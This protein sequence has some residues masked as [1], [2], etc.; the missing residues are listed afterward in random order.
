MQFI[1]LAAQQ[2]AIGQQIEKNIRNVISHGQYIMGPEVQ[3]LE[4]K[5]SAFCGVPFAVGCG[6]GTEALL[7]SLMALGVGPGDAVFCPTFTFIATAEVISLLGATPIFIDVEKTSFNLDPQCLSLAAKA[8]RNN[9]PN[10]YPLPHADAA[11]RPKAVIAVDLFG[12]PSD[13]GAIKNVAE[14]EGLAMV[15]DAAQSMGAVANGVRAGALAPLA[16]TSFFPAKPLGCYGDGGMVFCSEEATYD[17]LRSLR[18]HGKGMDKYDNVLIGLNAR[19]DTIQAAILLAKLQIFDDELTKRQNV[20]KIY[21]RELAASS[22]LITPKIP[23]D[24]Q[25]AWAQYSVLAEDSDARD[26]LRKSLADAG[27]PTA[28]YYPKPLHLQKAFFPGQLGIL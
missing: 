19:L 8:L 20:A 18:V 11:L 24:C 16:A 15:E 28:V 7:L 25:S 9:S 1:D 22:R 14:S 4:K 13:Y 5:L 10:D 2:A 27:V 26:R 6:S 17:T 23:D 3:Q 21:T 12:L